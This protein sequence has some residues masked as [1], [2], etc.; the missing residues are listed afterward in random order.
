[1]SE[2]ITEGERV[3]NLKGDYIGTVDRTMANER[4]YGCEAQV[5]VILYC[6]HKERFFIT[7]LTNQEYIN[8]AIQIKNLTQ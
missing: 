1:M 6:G 2:L 5:R 7:N 4:D 8:R 3:Y